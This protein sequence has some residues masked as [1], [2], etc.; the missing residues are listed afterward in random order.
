[1]TASSSAPSAG[2]GA[3]DPSGTSLDP[4]YLYPSYRS[5]VLRAPRSPLLEQPES[6]SLFGP[7]FGERHCAPGDADLTSHGSAPPLGERIVVHGRVVDTAGRPLRHQLVEIW[8]ANAAGRYAHRTDQHDAPLDPN[9]TGAGRCLTDGDGRYR[10]LTI[11]PG[12]YPWGNHPNAWRPAHI[13]VSVFGT[14]FSSRLVT[15]L[16]FP[17]DPLLAYDPMFQSIRDRSAAETLVA[18]LDLSTTIEAYALAY[19]FDLVVGA[20]RGATPI[21]GEGTP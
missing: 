7:V 16:Y 18:A 17:G 10:F 9:F 11:R 3:R 19:R 6:A 12:E 20:G 1:V 5:T 14:A 2:T 4:P 8:Q 13:H 15:Q 21:D